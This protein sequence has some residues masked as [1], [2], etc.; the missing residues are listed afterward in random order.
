MSAKVGDRATKI[1]ESRILKAVHTKMI[2]SQK[3]V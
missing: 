1:E 3:F 2:G